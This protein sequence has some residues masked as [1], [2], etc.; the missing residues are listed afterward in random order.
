MRINCAMAAVCAVLGTASGA[1]AATHTLEANF[2]GL[3]VVSPNA[4]PAFGLGDFTLNDVTGVFSVT[5]GTYQDLLGG[6][7]SVSLNG[8]ASAGTNAAVLTALTLDTP[9]AN[10]GT[11]SGGGTLSA[12]NVTD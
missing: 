9:G 7:T 11:F 8:P 12:G 4:S 3:Q 10:T 2:D 5:T 6:A 1:F